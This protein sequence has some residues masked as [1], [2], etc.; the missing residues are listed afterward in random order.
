[1]VA[2]KVVRFFGMTGSCFKHWVETLE[3]I[4]VWSH[5]RFRMTGSE[6]PKKCAPVQQTQL[7]KYCDTDKLHKPKTWANIMIN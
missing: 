4:F 2:E 7:K 3:T 1:M 5:D 6:A